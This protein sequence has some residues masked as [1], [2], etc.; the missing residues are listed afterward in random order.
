MLRRTP[1]TPMRMTAVPEAAVQKLLEEQGA[2]VLQ[3]EPSD[4]GPLRT[5]RYYVAVSDP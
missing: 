4:D 1:L 2:T 3:V 5:Q